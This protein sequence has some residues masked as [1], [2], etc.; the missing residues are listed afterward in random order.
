MP[1]NWNK[2]IAE[3]SSPSAFQQ[4][5]E[6]G[7]F[8]KA[9]GNKVYRLT[10]PSVL[11]AQAVV[12]KLP[13]GRT[14]LEISRGPVIAPSFYSSPL[15]GEER[16]GG[17]LINKLREIGEKEKAIF[18]R[19]SPPY[20]QSGTKMPSEFGAT[21]P[22]ILIH[23][24]EPAD[25]LLVDLNFSE[26]ELLEKMHHRTRYNIGLAQRSGGVAYDAT[27]KPKAFE[28]FFRLLEETGK[29]NNFR[30]WPRER[31]LKFK[32]FFV[33]NSS[34]QN[35]P[36]ARL[37]VGEQNEKIICAT[38]IM[39]F[40]DT[41]TYLYAASSG[42][43]AT[44]MPNLMLWEAI[45]EAKRR[46]KRWFDMWGAAPTNDPQHPWAGI[47]QFKSRYV[48][49]GETGRAVHFI[50]TWDYILYKKIYTLFRLGKKILG[51]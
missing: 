8:Q 14:Y 15:V 27:D 45:R 49:A 33:K 11:A 46:G 39:F 13:L 32:E 6:W 47:T 23:Q 19:F 48:K 25:T 51:R 12:K 42:D 36:Y 31:F 10:V 34:D 37:I 16:W 20:E 43:R 5:W 50:G 28:I 4:S 2:F 29:R 1:E 9:I 30:F 22:Q 40:G 17:V 24:K 44:K 21:A 7:E 3:H 41:A 18:F 35:T 26:Q 38:L